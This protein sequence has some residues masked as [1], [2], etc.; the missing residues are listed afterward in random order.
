[1]QY[2]QLRQAVEQCLVS[3]VFEA[4]WRGPA[5][6][7]P[8][9]QTMPTARYGQLWNKRMAVVCHMLCA[10]QLHTF[11]LASRLILGEELN[12]TCSRRMRLD[13][14]GQIP[15]ATIEATSGVYNPRR[16]LERS[17][18]STSGLCLKSTRIPTCLLNPCLLNS[19]CL[20]RRSR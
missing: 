15:M 2:A 4:S 9:L 13:Q 3:N 5:I 20:L 12:S 8:P 11:T 19:L 1:M 14:A 16:E 17:R 7:L 10:A 18:A 6:S